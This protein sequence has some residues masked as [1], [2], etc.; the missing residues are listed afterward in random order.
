MALNVLG[1]DLVECSRDPLTGF[2]R[3]GCCDTGPEDLG[4]HLVCIEATADFLRLSKACGNDLSTP[5]PELGFEGIKPGDRW[6]LCAE[7]WQEAFDLGFAPPVHLEATHILTL[8]FVDLANLKKHRVR[9]E[10]DD[11]SEGEASS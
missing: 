9:M 3:T 2:Y 8:E 1:T 10:G 11:V 6:C 7:R 4:H 5:R